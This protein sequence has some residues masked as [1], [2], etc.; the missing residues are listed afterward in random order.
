MNDK[1]FPSLSR[2]A[3]RDQTSRGTRDIADTTLKILVQ[4]TSGHL[5]LIWLVH[6]T[7]IICS[8]ISV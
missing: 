1:T 2:D 7:E 6:T 3:P 4:T 8:K 5:H